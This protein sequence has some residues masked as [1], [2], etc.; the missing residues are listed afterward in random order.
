MSDLPNLPHLIIRASAGT[1]KT[2]QLTHKYLELVQANAQPQSI[3]ATTFT[4]KAAGEMRRRIIDALQL[5]EQTEPEEAHKKITWSLAR[6]VVQQDQT[7]QWSL[8]HNPN[9]LRVM[10]FDSLCQSLTKQ[11]RQECRRLDSCKIGRRRSTVN[12]V[13]AR[14][15]AED[16]I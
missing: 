13:Y 7:K 14:N 5:A 12:L 3:L 9:R 6:A 10:T 4:R 15:K 16:K 2:Y 8:R 11:K 1:G